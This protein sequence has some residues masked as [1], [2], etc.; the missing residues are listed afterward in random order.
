[1]AGQNCGITGT[2]PPSCPMKAHDRLRILLYYPR[3]GRSAGAAAEASVFLLRSCSNII[4]IHTELSHMGKLDPSWPQL[5]RIITCGQVLIMCCARGE[6]HA[7]ESAGIFSRLIDL[8]DSHATLWPSAA[9]AAAAYKKAA[10]VLG[11]SCDSLKSRRADSR[12]I[13]TW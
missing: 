12:G 7:L 6:I 4:H 11:M 2:L 8:L 1:M 5:K 9:D 13:Y 3:L 10:K